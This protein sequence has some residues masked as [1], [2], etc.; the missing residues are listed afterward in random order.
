MTE[1]SVQSTKPRGRRAK[2]SA[3]QGGAGSATHLQV[4]YIKRN[5]P[6]YDLLG[7]E[8]LVKI[9]QAAETIL[10]E[11]GIE[12]RDDPETVRLFKEAGGV[13]TPLSEA[14]WNIKFE[15]GMVRQILKTAP[16]KFTQH[17]RNPARSVEIG[18]K[19]MVFAPSMALHLLWKWV[20]NAVM[21]R[22]QILKIS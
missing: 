15:P 18:G 22:W 20:K 13:V 9:E 3:R 4:P 2:K 5:I 17:A 14:I 21:G 19:S 12:F 6:T 10:S 8:S 11:I 16:G 1:R 7:E